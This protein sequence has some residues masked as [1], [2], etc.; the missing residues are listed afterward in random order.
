MYGYWHFCQ[1]DYSKFNMQT[2]KIMCKCN[3]FTRYHNICLSNITELFEGIKIIK[4]ATCTKVQKIILL[5]TIK[6]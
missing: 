6:V 4:N 3:V 5:N 1:I 2:V